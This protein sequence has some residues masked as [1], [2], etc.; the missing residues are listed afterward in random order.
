MFRS[1]FLKK[2]LGARFCDGRNLLDH[3]HVSEEE[4]DGHDLD[5]H[6]HN[7]YPDPYQQVVPFD[8]PLLEVS[9][10][11]ENHHPVVQ[12]HLLKC[13][14]VR[15]TLE[16]DAY[17]FYGQACEDVDNI[18]DRILQQNAAIWLQRFVLLGD[19]QVAQDAVQHQR[20]H[21]SDSFVVVV[22]V[23]K[24]QPGCA[25]GVH[26]DMIL[27]SN[28]DLDRMESRDV[29]FKATSS[30]SQCEKSVYKR[31]FTQNCLG[32]ANICRPNERQIP[33]TREHRA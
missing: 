28:Y 20:K 7:G 6:C 25:R 10:H 24:T 13:L 22:N 18:Y 17:E 16:D 31:L 29:R 9:V 32:T 19:Q 1:F 8:G 33:S 30:T 12:F 15:L 26:L 21:G 27:E 23:A 14:F 2:P 5:C 4:L 3:K 11:D